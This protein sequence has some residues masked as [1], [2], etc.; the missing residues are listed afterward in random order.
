MTH[1]GDGT[2]RLF[3][4]EKGGKIRIISQGQILP[5]PFLDLSSVITPDAAT[6]Q[7]LLGLAFD[8]NYESNGRFFVNYTD[9]GGETV[10]ARYQVSGD[11]NKASPGWKNH[12]NH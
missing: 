7:G 1:A 12:L 11:P 2:G 4:I 8:P 10:I 6:E 5:E 9:A 3:V